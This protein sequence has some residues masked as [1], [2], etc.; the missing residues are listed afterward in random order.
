MTL[1]AGPLFN[2]IAQ[3]ITPSA[4]GRE[5]DISALGAQKEFTEEEMPGF[6]I[7]F[8]TAVSPV[9]LMLLSTIVQLVTGHELRRMVLNLLFT[10]LVLQQ[11]NVDRCL[12][13]DLQWVSNKDV[14]CRYY[15]SVSNAFIME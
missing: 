15:G 10:L 4:Y 12:I 14:K 11:R 5:G 6:G 3:K 2:K 1:I 8:L 9:I 13:C 7:S